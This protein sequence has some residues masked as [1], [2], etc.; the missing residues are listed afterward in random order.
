[1]R[2]CRNRSIR[3]RVPS[4]SELNCGLHRIKICTRLALIC[5]SVSNWADFVV[6]GFDIS[7]VTLARRALLDATLALLSLFLLFMLIFTC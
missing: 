4:I 2:I 7:L 5:L 1:M 3:F 6:R